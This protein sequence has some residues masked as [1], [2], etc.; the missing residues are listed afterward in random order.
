MSEKHKKD[1]GSD[2]SLEKTKKTERVQK[3]KKRL[4]VQKRKKITLELNLK[5]YRII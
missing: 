3:T 5:S 4:R 2:Q 1:R